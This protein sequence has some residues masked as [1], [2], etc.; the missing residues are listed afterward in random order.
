MM[1]ID[2]EKARKMSL[3]ILEE[4]VVKYEGEV[5]LLTKEKCKKN[6]FVYFMLDLTTHEEVCVKNKFAEEIIK[7]IPNED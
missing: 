2:F 6:K 7:R 5:Y 4:Y 1:K 3:G